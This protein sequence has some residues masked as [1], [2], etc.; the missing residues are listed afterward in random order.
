MIDRIMQHAID[1]YDQNGWD[2]LVECWS[3]ADIAS[4]CDLGLTYEDTLKAISKVLQSVDDHR[5]EIQG[6]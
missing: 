1:H 3:T 5:R 4:F 6:A 2:I